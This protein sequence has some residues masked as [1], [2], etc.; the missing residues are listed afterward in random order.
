MP[1]RKSG[2]KDDARDFARKLRREMTTAE[3][4]LYDRVRARGLGFRVRRQVPI[5]PFFADFY[6][7]SVGLVIEL[8]GSFHHG[9][10]S[11]D[12]FR[13]RLLE[14]RGFTVLRFTNL[15]VMSEIENVCAKIRT[16]VLE[17]ARGLSHRRIP[18]QLV[19]MLEGK[20]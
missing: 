9:R 11:Y 5:G 6:V 12:R 16:H 18:A 17:L 19:Y 14:E 13:T 3:R 4:R 20:A 15:E 2:Q 7:A 1:S 10:E 8:D